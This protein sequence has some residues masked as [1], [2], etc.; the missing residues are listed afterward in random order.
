MVPSSAGRVISLGVFEDVIL[1][2]H[3]DTSIQLVE[4]ARVHPLS[5]WVLSQVEHTSVD[6]Y[7]HS[8]P[9]VL[10]AEER[11]KAL[12]NLK[13]VSSAHGMQMEMSG[14]IQHLFGYGAADP[15]LLL[16]VGNLSAIRPPIYKHFRWA[17]HT[18]D[19]WQAVFVRTVLPRINGRGHVHFAGG[20]TIDIG[21]NSAVIAGA[22]AAC[23]AG[24]RPAVN[25]RFVHEGEHVA[26]AELLHKHCHM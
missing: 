25:H 5:R 2:T 23:A 12:Y 26:F 3:A 9:S 15:E 22:K 6:V 11:W 14:R 18:F 17:H 10:P 13:F 7:L 4:Q 21:H 20:W 8:D 1:A 16:T 24:L 19:L